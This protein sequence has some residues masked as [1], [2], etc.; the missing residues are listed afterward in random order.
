MHTSP[1]N[2]VDDRF[3]QKVP[4]GGLARM[5]T[6]AIVLV[7]AALV[8][9]VIA[10]E[11]GVLR[12]PEV[13]WGARRRG[14]NAEASPSVTQCVAMTADGDRCVRAPT[15]RHTHYCWQ[16]QRMAQRLSNRSTSLAPTGVGLRLTRR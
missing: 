4:R 8:A 12:R 15:D 7:G 16:H 3:K 14:A 6:T 11:A 10:M 9:A 5:A 2:G 1:Q 13:R